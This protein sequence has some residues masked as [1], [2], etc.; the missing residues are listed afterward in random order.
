MRKTPLK[1]KPKPRLLTLKQATARALK[2]W[3]VLV[4][5]HADY[6]C[7]WCGKPAAHAHHMIAK[8]QGNRFRFM[9][10]NGVALCAGCH[11]AFHNRDSLTGWLKFKE[12]RPESYEIVKNTPRTELKLTAA[13]MRELLEDLRE[14]VARFKGAA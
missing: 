7:E 11:L 13:E 8:A 4:K 9:V 5:L 10:E 1:R 6:K 12:Q 2:E 14:Q 3:A